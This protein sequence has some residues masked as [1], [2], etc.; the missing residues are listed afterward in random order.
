[1]CKPNKTHGADSRDIA[2][3]KADE[4]FLE[5]ITDRSVAQRSARPS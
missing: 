3:K 5:Q 4:S 2:G 1:M